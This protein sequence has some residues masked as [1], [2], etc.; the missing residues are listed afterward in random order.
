[1]CAQDFAG[2]LDLRAEVST[3]NALQPQRTENGMKP[4]SAV[5]S[6]GVSSFGRCP[7]AGLGLNPA[8]R[9]SAAL[10]PSLQLLVSSSDPERREE[11]RR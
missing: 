7:F 8:L 9:C 4:N 3:H 10:T 11:S 2:F 6:C 1:M 5:S